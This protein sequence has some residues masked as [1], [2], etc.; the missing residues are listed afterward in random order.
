MPKTLYMVP[1]PNCSEDGIWVNWEGDGVPQEPY[2]RS[3]VKQ[4]EPGETWPGRSPNGSTRATIETFPEGF[5]KVVAIAVGADPFWMRHEFLWRD[6]QGM[7]LD[8]E[9]LE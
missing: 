1:G 2:M 5:K 6:D 8:G 9:T 4:V 3:E 7:P